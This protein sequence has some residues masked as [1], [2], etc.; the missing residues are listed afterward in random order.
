MPVAGTAHGGERLYNW[1]AKLEVFDFLG[2]LWQNFQHGQLPDIGTWKYMLMALFVMLQGRPSAVMSGIAAAT[3]YLNLWIVIAV[4]LLARI[5]ADVFWYGLGSAGQ[6]ER[7]S[8]RTRVLNSAIDEAQTRIRHQPMRVVLLSKFSGG[9]A[10]PTIVVAGSAGI[11]L[12][13]WL[14]AAFIGEFVWTTPLQLL[15][16]FARNATGNLDN[17]TSATTAFSG[18]LFLGLGLKYLLARIRAARSSS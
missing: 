12:L 2:E 11:P 14:P 9:L 13:Q 15:G 4:A 8:R 16:Y 10:I 1:R 3:G 18:L 17:I 6:V 7:L 5:G